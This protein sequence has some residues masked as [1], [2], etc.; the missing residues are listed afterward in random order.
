MLFQIAYDQ[1]DGGK[2]I[3]DRI[4]VTLGLWHVY[5]HT[6]FAVY[7]RFADC[8]IAGCF[9]SLFPGGIFKR[10]PQYLS[11]IVTIFTYIRLAY[12]T[13][14]QQLDNALAREDVSDSSK[15][16]LINMKSLCEFYIPAVI[17]ISYYF[18]PFNT[19]NVSNKSCDQCTTICTLY[20][21]FYVG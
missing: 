17:H 6:C 14:R 18:V 20:A 4:V 3:R 11:T 1:S 19:H 7:D 5:K 9:H 2:R 15:Q 10:K 8:F 12:P 13:F 21:L 16:H